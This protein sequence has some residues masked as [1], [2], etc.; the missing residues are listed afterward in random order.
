MRMELA[1]SMIKLLVIL[2]IRDSALCRSKNYHLY[3]ISRFL[4]LE[5][6]AQG[7]LWGANFYA[8]IFNTRNFRIL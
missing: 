6:L 1:V 5:Y 3:D 8:S 2:S 4:L 7:Q